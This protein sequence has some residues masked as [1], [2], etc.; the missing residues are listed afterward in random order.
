MR[1]ITLFSTFLLCFWTQIS[2]A[3]TFSCGSDALWQQYLQ[4]NPEQVLLQQGLENNYYEQAVKALSQPQADGAA[5]Y[6][7]PVVVHIIHNN[8]MGDIT[9]AQVQQGIQDLN[10][11]FANTGY[12][13]NGNGAM[14]PFQFCLAQR[15]PTGAPTNGIDRVVSPLTNMFM[16]FEDL[17]VKDLSRWD[18]KKYINIWLVNEILSVNIGPGVAG[19]AFFPGAHGQAIDGIMM[20][21]RWFGTS[22]AKTTV[23]VHEMG[24]YLGLLHTF[25][26]GCTNDDCLLNGDR[27]CDTPPDQSTASQPCSVVENTCSTDVNSGFSTDQ[28][29]MTINYMDYAKLECANAFTQGQSD[30]MVFY[31]THA[32]KSL[33]QSI[34]CN[35]PCVNPV[36]AAFSA[37]V[38]PTVVAGT[39][40]VFINNSINGNTYKWYVNNV[41]VGN[42]FNLNYAMN[43]P[44][45]VIVRLKVSGADTTCM[46]STIDTFNVYCP[47]KS[48]FTI[49]NPK[50]QPGETINLVALPSVATQWEWTVNGAVVGNGQSASVTLPNPGVYTICLS[51]SNAF[52]AETLCKTID[53]KDP[54]LCDRN[55]FL[56][57]QD[58]FRIEEVTK[59]PDGSWLGTGYKSLADSSTLYHI[60]PDLE[61]SSGLYI[62]AIPGEGEFIDKTFVVSGNCVVGIGFSPTWFPSAQKKFFIFKYNYLSKTMVWIRLYQSNQFELFE[63]WVN[64][65]ELSG[66]GHYLLNSM[67]VNTLNTGIQMEIDDVTGAI[68]NT[69]SIQQNFAFVQLWDMLS[70]GQR[71]YT[72]GHIGKTQTDHGAQLNMWSPTGQLVW[73]KYYNNPQWFTYGRSLTV[74]ENELYILADGF[75]NDTYHVVIKTDL[76]GQLIWATK[77]DLSGGTSALDGQNIV[78]VSDGVIMLYND[79]IVENTHLHKLDTA[80]NLMW[81]KTLDLP[82][83][84][85]VNNLYADG[86]KIILVCDDWGNGRSIL[87]RLDPESLVTEECLFFSTSNVSAAKLPMTAV[88]GG[89][90]TPSLGWTT[91]SAGTQTGPLNFKFSNVCPPGPCPEICDNGFDDDQD[92][93][94]DCFDADD[95]PC[96][97]DIPS[98]ATTDTLGNRIAGRLDWA[99]DLL[100]VSTISTPIV[101]N[102]NPLSDSIPEIIVPKNNANG[103]NDLSPTIL[104]FQGD[105]SNANL[106]DVLTIQGDLL[107]QPANFPVVGDINHDGIPELVVVCA[108]RFIRVYS[109]Y[110][111]GASP[112]MQLW[113]TSLQQVSDQALR[114]YLADFNQDGVPEIFAGTEV[115]QFDITL[116]GSPV[117]QR[118]SGANQLPYG[119]LN[120]TVTTKFSCSPVAADLLRPVD[121]NGDP[122]CDGLEI[123]AGNV[124]YSVDLDP[125]DG[126]GI[127]VKKQLDLNTMVFGT[128]YSDG[129]TSVGD[130]DLDGTLDVLVAGRRGNAAGVY[131]WNKFGL[132]YFF[133]YPNGATRG[134][135]LVSVANVYNDK[136]SG[137]TQDFPEI[138]SSCENRLVCYNLNRAFQSPANPW[139]WTQTTNDLSGMLGSSIFD[140][141]H[142]SRPE[143]LLRD[144]NNLRIIYGGAAPFPAGVDVNR[145]WA[146]FPMGSG[147]LDDYPVVADLDNDGQAEVAV[148]GHTNP[149]VPVT[150]DATGRL[151][152]FEANPWVGSLWSSARPLWNQFGYFYV[153]VNDDLTIPKVQQPTQLEFPGIGSGK[154]PFNQF[155]AQLSL[156]DGNFDPFVPLPDVTVTA[157]NLSCTGD[158]LRV[159]FEVC[160]TGSTVLPAGMPLRLYVGDPTTGPATLMPQ[161]P[162]LAAE[163]PAGACDS[164]FLLFPTM[165]NQTVFVVANDNGSQATPFDFDQD[166][167]ATGLP[168]CNFQNNMTSFPLPATKPPLDLGP[169]VLV[170]QNGVWTFNAG[171][172]FA[173]YKWSTF[174]SDSTTTVYTPGKYWVEAKDLCGGL[175]SDTVEV[176]VLPSS[177]FELGPDTLLCG[178]AVLE[179]NVPGFV[180]YQWTPATGLSCSDCPNPTASVAADITYTLSAK[181]SQ[182]CNSVD[183]IRVRLQVAPGAQL[184]TM[185]CAGSSLT[186]NG[187]DIPAGSS[188]VFYFPAAGSSCDSS[189]TVNVATLPVYQTSTTQTICQ[190]DSV[191]IFGQWQTQAGA[192]SQLFQSTQGCDSTHTVQLIVLPVYQTN[193][194]LTI[195]AGDSVQVYGQWQ[196]QSGNYSQTFQTT[197]G[198]DSTHTVQLTVLPQFQTTATLSICAGD[199]ALVFGQW[200]T[201]AGLFQQTYIAQNGCDSS[202]TI[203][204]AVLPVFETLENL[205]IC[206][207]DSVQIF[208]QWRQQPGV[209]SQLLAAQNGCDSS[210]Q[211]TLSV[212]PLQQTQSNQN[213]CAGDSTL[214]FGQWQH[215]AGTYNQSYTAF[216]GCDSTHAIVLNVLP[217][218]QTQESL[219]LC[220]GDSVQVF[221]QWQHLAG[222]YSQTYTAANL[223]DSTHRINL[224]VLPTQQTQENRQIC[225]GDSILIFGQWQHLPG[226]FSQTFQALSGCDSTHRIALEVLP[227]LQTAEQQVVCAGDSVLV[228]GQ[229]Q[230]QTGTFSQSFVASGGCDSTHTITLSQLP[231][232]Q[233]QEQKI[234][235]SG[236]SALIFGQWRHQSGVF[237]QIFTAV[238]GC[239]ST[240]T[241]E[242]TVAPALFTQAAL[243]ICAGDSV[244]VFG[245]WQH[246]AGQFS[247]TFSASA[248]CDSTH[249]V[250]VEVW[251]VPFTQE[252]RNICAGDSALIFGQWQS[253]PGLYSRVFSAAATGCDSTHSV[254]LTV[255]PF[256]QS[257]ESRTLC[258]GDSSSIFGQWQM[259]AGA[260]SQ[261]FT[262]AGGCDS[263]HTVV[264][265]VLPAPAANVATNDPGCYGETNGTI[266]VPVP[267]AGLSYSLD[268]LQYQ[269]QASFTGL[270]GGDYQL[271]IRDVNGCESV[272]PLSLATPDSLSLELPADTTI[273]LGQWIQLQALTN[274]LTPTYAWTPANYL[275]CVQCAKPIATP[276]VSTTYTLTIHDAQGCTVSA[277]TRILVEGPSFFLPNV[278]KPDAAG[279]NNLFGVFASP[280]I[281]Q[282]LN[283]NIYDRWGGQVYHGESFVA[284]GATGWDGSWRGLPCAPG[285]YVYLVEVELEDG[286]RLKRSGD[287]TLVR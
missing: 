155:L 80:G 11:A 218:V 275:D 154:R 140:F 276:T 85:Y 163:L 170:C 174:S 149:G 91:K 222:T 199:S 72:I 69:K 260:Y 50:P 180:E 4:D 158:S 198:C 88:D 214:I 9:D 273:Y 148:T 143:I 271:F 98:C 34:G 150:G 236:D 240:H 263:T 10:A 102:L 213:I 93:Y 205:A 32:R 147:T 253:Q 211:I 18:P 249:T 119:R 233:T 208:G 189:F 110:Q 26:G 113:A 63:E 255:S 117:L 146:L 277:E 105:G 234:I 254:T 281:R 212:K 283:L 3:Q 191:P 43:T 282:V 245:Q 101:A 127:Q 190:G 78:A 235:C 136:L 286:S 207:G 269:P 58:S 16:E 177:I 256:L 244:L 187:T 216:N 164:V 279:Q 175:Y 185:L 59:L 28:N 166:F 19:Y 195:C 60:T 225:S 227:A 87:I 135:G 61:L 159:T 274:A 124:I 232:W 76:D 264:L 266:T 118:V 25:E 100:A 132:L 109:Q 115:Y 226:V 40:V 250:T 223:C 248:G 126:D 7:L 206:A 252:A 228:F 134:G 64:F 74:L 53:I 90:L 268:G 160:N 239:D 167:P 247:Q 57:T 193:E 95:C 139:W 145:N 49:D 220:A 267:A 27:V 68:L 137:A 122:D 192:Y 278:F 103:P 14:T 153:P 203:Q 123:A 55:K 251:S 181:L 29:D 241:V 30:R 83:D 130:I 6:T 48:T 17:L 2:L 125:L 33:L 106:P 104:I 112:A 173:S 36:T 186:W 196:F 182:G 62:N 284:D 171:S 1:L 209:Y 67:N 79:N 246:A 231:L 221:G 82:N 259:Q 176:K 129:Y 5:L 144:Q 84:F 172:G 210:V 77:I 165:W 89:L 12:Y 152:V 24:H 47:L 200:Q 15:T 128:T 161:T 162:V 287:V 238:T 120:T 44:G 197:Q 97:A 75:G 31:I 151:W 73:S 52:C 243:G 156:L 81:S 45:V 133:N 229:W 116:P 157:R 38:G 23:L 280:G 169:D 66:N 261:S 184:D 8:G 270:S 107:I 121:C 242:L 20:E 142:D 13:D 96:A 114:P 70:V 257:Q 21:S 94:V 230:H 46:E 215:L 183:S 56:Y 141:N 138:I 39:P 42:S 179:F 272:L 224:T 188:Q 204:L 237:S 65:A 178:G 108:D 194:P 168:E 22:P 285:V 99:S 41:L 35:P 111:P 131:V 202:H 37:S 92:G 265:E 217:T 71:I 201:Q 262:A 258:A 219:S 86:D 54:A 51:T